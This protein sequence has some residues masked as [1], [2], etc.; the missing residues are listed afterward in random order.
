MKIDFGRANEESTI[1]AYR[2][3]LSKFSFKYTVEVSWHTD[4]PDARMYQF[5]L[6]PDK[7]IF[8]GQVDLNFFAEYQ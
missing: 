6:Q 4:L 2:A 8:D 3:F 7:I 1:A 5:H